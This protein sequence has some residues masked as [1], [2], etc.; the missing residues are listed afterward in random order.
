MAQTP[1]LVPF[2]QATEAILSRVVPLPPESVALDQIVGRVL[3]RT[4]HAVEDVPAFASSAMDGYALPRAVLDAIQAG[5]EA[6]ARVVGEIAA[7]APGF[8]SCPVDDA[9]VR[10]FTGGVVPEWVAAVLPQ[11]RTRREGDRVVMQGPLAEG[12]HV[13]R[14]G[15]DLKAGEPVLD[16]GIPLTPPAVAV[17]ASLGVGQVAVGAL[18]RVGILVTGTELVTDGPIAVGQIRDSNGPA[19]AAAARACG[20]GTVLVA[21]A[22]DDAD[23]LGA[24]LDDL[25][26]RVDVLLT[27]GGVSVGDHD[28]VK[29]VLEAS[30]VQRILWGVAQRPGRP[31]YAGIR[32]GTVVL[33]LPGNPASAMATFLAHGWPLLRHLQGMQVRQVRSRAVLS[34]PVHKAPGFTAMVRGRRALDGAVVTA[35]P[36]GPQES[37]QML[38]FSRSDCL[39]LVPPDV[40]GLP[41]GTTVDV[42]PFPWAEFR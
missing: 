38:P 15:G 40:D 22:S 25:W 31:F 24:V 12:A 4:V 10:I 17:L 8:D 23:A 14:A 36:S 34:A 7:G 19:L 27:S 16:A 21:R 35:R 42:I 39:I 1:E 28:L 29:D 33:G 3:A 32:G 41:A 26:P 30:G 11:E 37:H 18:P 6:A 5:G 13:R 2:H 20:A 9:V